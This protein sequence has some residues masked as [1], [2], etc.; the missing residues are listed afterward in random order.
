M[1]DIFL[2]S[3]SSKG[4]AVLQFHTNFLVVKDQV[5]DEFTRNFVPTGF[6]QEIKSLHEIRGT[7]STLFTQKVKTIQQFLIK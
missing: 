4:L 3:L 1:I 6:R 2:R 5:Q 7:Q